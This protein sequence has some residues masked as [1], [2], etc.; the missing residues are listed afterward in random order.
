MRLFMLIAAAL[1][2]A[3]D[4]WAQTSAPP[5]LADLVPSLILQEISLPTTPIDG[6]SHEAHFSPVESEESSNP[7]VAIVQSF[8]TLMRVQLSSFPVGSSAGGL[9]YEFDETLG[10][11]RRSST[12]FGPAFAER[13]LTIGRGR[14]NAGVTF[15]HT[16][17]SRFEGEDLE[18]GSIKFYLRHEECC[19][20]SGVGGGGGGSGGG[21]GG[22]G[23]GPIPQP[24]GTRLNPAFEGDLIEASLSLEA[25]TDTVAFLANYGLTSRWD[26]GLVVPLVHVDLDARVDATILR[27]ATAANPVLHT[28]ETGNPQATQRTFQES[29]SATGLG[30]VLLRTKYRFMQFAGGGLAAAVD[31]RLPTGDEEDLLGTGGTQVKLQLVASGGNTRF[32][33][34]V[35]IGYT[36]ASS[37]N[38]GSSLLTVLGGDQ[39]VPDEFNYV[40]GVEFV[41]HPRLTVM[42]DV[43]GRTLLDAGRLA[44]TSK[45]FQYQG[46]T[47]VQTAM[48]D[49]FEQRPGSLNVLLGTVGAKFN[50]VGDLLLSGSVLFPLA[51]TGL[52]SRFTT[53]VG[54]DYAF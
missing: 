48:F 4:V 19:T 40:G 45:T 50:P 36:A 24:N 46:A 5:R 2:A 49:E 1:A 22:G 31:V 14:L 23:G 27:L 53:V 11:L 33:Q 10:T 41:A 51:D 8:N 3:P 54:I 15:Q 44:V 21:G 17:Y 9:T 52:R 35:N 43:V 37:A 7:A 47:S 28:F 42:G 20:A 32:A 16:R 13:A 12:S 6:V 30:D 39:T 29:G 25:K 18:D 38:V 34:H 26:V